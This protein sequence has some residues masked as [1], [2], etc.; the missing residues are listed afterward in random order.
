MLFVCECVF[1]QK[2]FW[3]EWFLRKVIFKK[4][5]FNASF[6][7]GRAYLWAIFHKNLMQRKRKVCLEIL[8][9]CCLLHFSFVGNWLISSNFVAC[10]LLQAITSG[11]MTSN[12]HPTKFDLC[13]MM[14]HTILFSNTMNKLIKH[15]TF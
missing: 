2:W 10:L 12:W 1:K 7:L 3:K 11:A 6:C 13:V 15:V 9:R 4:S 5:D 8:N 14:K